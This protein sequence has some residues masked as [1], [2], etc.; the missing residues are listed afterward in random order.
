MTHLLLISTTIWLLFYLTIAQATPSAALGY[1][2][3][4]PTNFEHFAYV[5]PN[6]PKE[7]ELI[8]SGYGNFDRLNPFLLKGIS[9]N[10]L[11]ELMFDTLMVKS[12]DEPFSLYGLLAEDIELATD[13]LS[14]IFRLNPK[15][16]F[17]DDSEVT[18]EDVKFSFDTLKSEQA[19]PQ[20]RLY[21]RDIVQAEVLDKYLVRFKFAKINPE[22][23]LII[24]EMPVFSKKA[25]G[26]RHFDQVVTE[27]L[28][29]SGPYRVDS[30]KMGRYI[31]YQ[32]RSNYW[33]KDLNVRRG[34][35]NFERVTFKYYQDMDIAL[36]ALKAGEFDFMTIYNSKS[37]AR[38]FF[39]EKFDRGQIKKTELPHQNNAG[40]QGF[41][42]NLRKPLFQDIRVRQA[43][44]LAY[45]FEWANK[46]LFY[47]QYKRC[48]SYF[49]NSELASSGLPQGDELALLEPFRSQLPSTV[50]TEV[51]QPA[52][53]DLPHSLRD[54]LRKAKSLL[55]EAGWQLKDG[56]L[57]KDSLKLEFQIMLVQE[58]FDRILAPFEHNLKKLGI[59][60]TYRKVDVALYQQQAETF[61]FDVIV[62]TFP[63]SQSPGNELISVWHSS[64]AD[65]EGSN[66]LVGLK[67]PAV[68]ALIE[69]VIYA[70]NRQA[71]ITAVHALDRV[72]LHGDYVVPNWYIGTHRISYWDK[73]DRP[74]TIPLYY[75]VDD[76][77][78]Q[79]WWQRNK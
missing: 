46:N 66:N 7:G 9:A 70:P 52:T 31:T 24:A 59:N 73:F 6:A 39:G 62:N 47:N 30:V 49:S 54:N 36:E 50:F 78:I 11:T 10:G 3:K 8:L 1:D 68:D 38:D 20:Y 65:Q 60:I 34:M 44:N 71:L 57:Q 12:L 13:K 2:P 69:K 23:H 45:D 17:S 43:I 63:Q 58:G 64:S 79:A 37:W 14:V 53:T 51:W 40:M 41:V 29:A 32:H 42:F 26:E 55:D 4:Y 5:N 67:N 75:Q 76:W 15:A 77:V 21:W 16:R 28:V 33:A 61:D 27:S 74:K 72:L 19:H 22:L 35:F 48:Y 18:A 56:V 25:V